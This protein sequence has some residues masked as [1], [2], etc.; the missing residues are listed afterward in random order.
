MK[1]WHMGR[2]LPST[3]L[4]QVAQAHYDIILLS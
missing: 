2:H 3:V 1:F 4:S